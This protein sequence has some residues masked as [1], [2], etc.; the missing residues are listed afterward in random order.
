MDMQLIKYVDHYLGIPSVIAVA[1]LDKLLFPLSIFKKKPK[2]IQ[3]ILFIKFWGFGNL[4]MAMP[5][6]KAVR[7]RFPDAEINFLTLKQNKGILDDLDFIDRVIYF[8][9]GSLAK[10]P[11]NFLDLA[12][13]FRKQKM[14]I[15]VDLEQF[16]R[17]SALFTYFTGAPVR[18]GYKTR[19]QGKHYLYTK[20]IEYNNHQHTACT[21]FDIAKSLGSDKAPKLIKVKYSKQDS[22]IVDE[23]LDKN[24]AS[25]RDTLIGMHIGSGENAD[26]RRWPKES[27]AALADKLIEKHN[28][29]I[30]FTGSPS[31]AEEINKALKLMKHKAFSTAG[32]FSLK[33]LAAFMEHCRMFVSNDT[34]PLHLAAAM[35]IKCVCFFGPNT[36]LLYGPYSDN[37]LVF[38]KGLQCSPCITNF[39]A[40]TTNCKDPICI[41]SITVKEVFDAMSKALKN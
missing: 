16:S 8:E 7:E 1:A 18:I 25:K 4:I 22:K 34:G 20:V 31:E 38:Y 29:K 24:K 35:G 19:N 26:V 32:V 28:A 3:K 33:Q 12:N 21:F 17:A 6:V 39:N 9:I 10:F 41:T 13:S 2:K 30:F 15:V 23:F 36:P 11:F 40:K 5:A 27:F 37:N 14:D